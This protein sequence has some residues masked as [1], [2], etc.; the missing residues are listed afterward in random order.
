[1][2]SYDLNSHTMTTSGVGACD[3]S[4]TVMRLGEIASG[5]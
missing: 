2:G 3:G 4:V 1:M 5:C